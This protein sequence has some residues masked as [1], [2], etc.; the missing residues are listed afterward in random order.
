[1]S[2]RYHEA[3]ALYDA[4]KQADDS[5]DDEAYASAEELMQV[6]AEVHTNY[7]DVLYEN[8]GTPTNYEK[9][10]SPE[11][12]RKD[13]TFNQ[14]TLEE[15]QQVVAPD[16]YDDRLWEGDVSVPVVLVKHHMH[17]LGG[18]IP[19]HMEE[20]TLEAI[21]IENGHPF[22]Q[23]V[24]ECEPQTE[25]ALDPNESLS[26]A[27]MNVAH[28]HTANVGVPGIQRGLGTSFGLRNMEYKNMLEHTRKRGQAHLFAVNPGG[29]TFVPGTPF[30]FEENEYGPIT[31][32]SEL[33]ANSPIPSIH[34][35]YKMG[36]ELQGQEKV[37]SPYRLHLQH[38]EAMYAR[39]S[40][41]Q[42]RCVVVSG[43]DLNTL[44]EVQAALDAGFPTVFVNDSGRFAE[45]VAALID[46]VEEVRDLPED[47]REKYIRNKIIERVLE[48]VVNDYIE[49]D[50]GTAS[51][52]DR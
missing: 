30:P 14:S 13:V 51:R 25:Q 7:A 50:I 42:P 49:S 34:T 3:R 31:P 52:N 21:G 41:G 24:G 6:F 17:E 10:F 46:D 28:E 16:G 29:N 47:E 44:F 39:L 23:V 19:F 40:A 27:I 15:V 38:K 45:V 9:R 22:I 43:G 5:E 8:A 11:L 4:I 37:N 35:P 1:M 2:N 48:D 32:R 36:L 18:T 12:E 26:R 33:F 20:E